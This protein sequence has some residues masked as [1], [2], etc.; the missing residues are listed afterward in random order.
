[1]IKISRV[2]AYQGMDEIDFS[3]MDEE[4]YTCFNS[5]QRHDREQTQQFFLLDENTIIL[6][7]YWDGEKVHTVS[8][9]NK[10]DLTDQGKKAVG[11]PAIGTT[12]KVSLTLPDEIWEMV[13]KRKE[14]WGASQSQTLRMMIEGYWKNDDSIGVRS[15]EAAKRYDELEN[16]FY[17]QYGE[18]TPS[19]VFTKGID[20][21]YKEIFSK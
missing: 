9:K 3:V 14:V 15:D 7:V 12:K 13:K 8:F 2:E 4:L 5:D 20:L 19:Q 17:E 6:E 16:Y 10:A 1:M 18:D 21:L 11:R